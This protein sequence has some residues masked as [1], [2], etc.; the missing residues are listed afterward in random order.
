MGRGSGADR[1]EERRRNVAAG[2]GGW[3]GGEKLKRKKRQRGKRP[4]L[5]WER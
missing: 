4:A 2:V 1:S 5:K 3:E